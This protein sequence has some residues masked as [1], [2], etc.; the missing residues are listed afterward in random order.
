[1]RRDHRPHSLVRVQQFV[2]RLYV[3]RYL[4]PQFDE[5]GENVS[6]LGARYLEVN[7][8]RISVGD[9][10]VAIAAP[11]APIRLNVWQTQTGSGEIRIGSYSILSPGV[12][13]SSASSVTI[14]S[15]C[16]VAQDA[17]IT[18]ADWHDLYH[19]A[20]APGETK[21]IC[22]DDNVWIGDGVTVCKGVHIGEN[23]VV[24]AGAVVVRDIP[25]NVVAAGNPA[26]IVRKLDPKA[27]STTREQFIQA[28]DPF[29]E[30][31]EQLVREALR[32]NTLLGWIRSRLARNRQS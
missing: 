19:R 2:N 9:Y 15:S 29:V 3:R 17:Y 27:P 26:K 28:F 6:L 32:G 14:G 22:L 7:G 16:M 10:F 23:S 18:D 1:M 11:D 31:A 12:R 30:T 21:P 5:V 13:I 20:F 4:F 24:G 8:P 25:P